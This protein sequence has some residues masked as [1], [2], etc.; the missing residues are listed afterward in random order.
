MDCSNMN[1]EESFLKMLSLK[2]VLISSSIS[3]V[4]SV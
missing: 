1:H 4:V 3:E 2:M